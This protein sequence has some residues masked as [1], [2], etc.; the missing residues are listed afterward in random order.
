MAPWQAQLQAARPGAL[1]FFNL[2]GDTPFATP[3]AYSACPGP[4]GALKRP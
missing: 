4:S 3:D 2:L 1:S